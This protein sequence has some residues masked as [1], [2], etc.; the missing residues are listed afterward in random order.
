MTYRSRYCQRCA[1]EQKLYDNDQPAPCYSCGGT[2]FDLQPKKHST[3]R[4]YE[5]N[6]ARWPRPWHGVDTD[7]NFLLV[8]GIRPEVDDF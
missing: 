1:T 3:G 2:N 6:D 4:G 7:W 8:T 5:L